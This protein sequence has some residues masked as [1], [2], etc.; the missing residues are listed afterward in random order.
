MRRR[1]FLTVGIALLLGAGAESAAPADPPRIGFLTRIP[2]SGSD[3]E[4]FRQGLYE[5]GYFDGTNILRDWQQHGDT[6]SGSMIWLI[7]HRRSIGRHRR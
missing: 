4:G 5:L 7:F 6:G 3:R 1:S 2:E